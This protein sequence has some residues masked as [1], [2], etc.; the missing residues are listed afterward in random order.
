MM[1]NASANET[2]GIVA[3]MTNIT[4]IV[5]SNCVVTITG[6]SVDTAGVVYA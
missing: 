4:V 2:S 5:T 1:P 6:T 3:S